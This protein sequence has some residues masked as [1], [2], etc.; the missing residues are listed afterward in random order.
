MAGRNTQANHE[1][2]P[3]PYDYDALDGISKDT[4]TFHHDKHHAG[5]VTKWNEIE[6]ALQGEAERANANANYSRYAEL[7]RRESFNAAGTILHDLYWQVL[8]GT[9]GEPGGRLKELLERDFGSY[10]GWKKDSSRRRPRCRSA[11]PCSCIRSW[12]GGCTTT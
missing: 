4:V 3:L 10:E 5:Y 9:G 12:M 11:G 7:K 8:G 6:K 2:M 1:L